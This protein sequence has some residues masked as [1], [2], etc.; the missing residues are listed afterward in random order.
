DTAADKYLA[1]E[2]L[3]LSVS[4]IVMG[5]CPAQYEDPVNDM[6]SNEVKP[7]V[8]VVAR[9]DCDHYGGSTLDTHVL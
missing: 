2:R 1:L 5:L 7:I 8:R 6:F 3:R 4:C 9:H